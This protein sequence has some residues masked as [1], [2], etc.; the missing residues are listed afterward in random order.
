MERRPLT[1]T[2]TLREDRMDLNYTPEEQAFREEV[3]QF[4]KDELPSDIYAKVKGGQ[5][6]TR[7]DHIRWQ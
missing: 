2:P 6:L 3:R 4:L 5:R 7:D 1:I